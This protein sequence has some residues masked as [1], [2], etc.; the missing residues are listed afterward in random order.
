MLRDIEKNP[1]Y[2]GQRF[3]ENEDYYF[4]SPTT[5][6]AFMKALKENGQK[7][8]IQNPVWDATAGIGT[9]SKVLLDAG[10]EV[11]STDSK[12]LWDGT[13]EEVNFFKDTREWDGTIL[14]APPFKNAT[15]Y[16][17]TA[18]N[19]LNSGTILYYA[20]INLLE[21]KERAKL[22]KEIPLHSIW[23][24]SSRQMMIKS[25]DFLTTYYSTIFYAW[26]VWKTGFTG[27]TKLYWI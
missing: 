9:F 10:F 2:F 14:L 3:M 23:F 8:L 19:H 11:F 12:K 15:K 22:F 18:L 13:S 21:S 7:D 26:F 24:H 27:E 1:N 17:Y 6:I 5:L 4:P 25:S 20:K 16:C